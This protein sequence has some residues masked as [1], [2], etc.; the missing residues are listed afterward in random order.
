MNTT[1]SVYNRLFAEDKVELA[2]ERVELGL[3][4]DNATR[5]AIASLNIAEMEKNIAA[6]K[7]RISYLEMRQGKSF[8]NC[9]DCKR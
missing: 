3:V 1:K 4:E 5:I 9:K 6:I 7:T 2:S 8:C